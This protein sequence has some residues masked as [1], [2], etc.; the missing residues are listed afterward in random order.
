MN[1][2]L[3]TV[4]AVLTVMSLSACGSIGKEKLLRQWR[5]RLQRQSINRGWFCTVGR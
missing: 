3:I 4:V 5:N 1:K 2:V